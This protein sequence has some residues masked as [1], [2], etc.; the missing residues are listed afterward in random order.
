MF[1]MYKTYKI[2]AKIVR[3]L[4]YMRND[5]DKHFRYINIFVKHESYIRDI[6]TTLVRFGACFILTLSSNT[7]YNTIYIP[8]I[9]EA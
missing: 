3:K 6:A 5:C 9:H 4:K 7:I 1:Y 8:Y 2:K